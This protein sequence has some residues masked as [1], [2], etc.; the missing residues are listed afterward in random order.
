VEKILEIRKGET[1]I[2]SRMMKEAQP[3]KIDSLGPAK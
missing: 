2:G 1:G 3:I